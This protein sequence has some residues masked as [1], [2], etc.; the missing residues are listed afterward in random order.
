MDSKVWWLIWLVLMAAPMHSAEEV[1][2][3][4]EEPPVLSE[5]TFERTEERTDCRQRDPLRRPFFGDTHVHTS[6]SFD[7]RT[8]DTRNSPREAYRF[9][10][11]GAMGIQPYDE[12]GNS[13]RTIQLDRPLDWTSLSDHAELLGTVRICTTP[14]MDGYYHP[15]CIA[16][17]NFPNA[18]IT[19]LA[20]PAL[21]P[22]IPMG[23]G[24]L[25]K[26]RFAL[27][28]TRARWCGMR[29]KPQ[30]RRPTIAPPNAAS[31]ASSATSGLAPWRTA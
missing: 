21:I 22:Q 20:G 29:F 9:A 23:V 10:K 17:R 27:S 31:R 5:P 4:S 28:R 30:P 19:F 12:A 18:G 15:A 2:R 14:G 24:A 6:Y 7:A 11:G 3:A 8:Q 26:R 25:R 13:T 16:M 1:A